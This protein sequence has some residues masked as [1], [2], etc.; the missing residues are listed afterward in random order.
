MVPLEHSVK[1]LF[2]NNS[3]PL[4]IIIDQ[5]KILWQTKFHKVKIWENTRGKNITGTGKKAF[6]GATL[7]QPKD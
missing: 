4:E 5:A 2:N 1:N 3:C 6:F 7:T